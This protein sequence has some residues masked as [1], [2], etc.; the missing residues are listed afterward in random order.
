MVGMILGSMEF[1]SSAIEAQKNHSTLQRIAL[2]E[3]GWSIWLER[4][5]TGWGW[6]STS[7]LAPQSPT[8]IRHPHFHST[9]VQ[10]IVELGVFGWLFVAIWIMGSFWLIFLGIT[11][12]VDAPA[13]YYFASASVVLLGSGFV[14]AMLFGG[15]RA[16]QV[17]VALA[18]TWALIRRKRELTMRSQAARDQAVK[19]DVEL[20]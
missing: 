13:G 2:Y 10:F 4:P 1:L 6:G 12:R 19:N 7:L 18:L 15:D 9:Y 8:D 5:F 14:H 17:V 3:A 20:A 11:F 16:V